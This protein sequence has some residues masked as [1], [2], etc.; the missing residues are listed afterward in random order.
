MANIWRRCGSIRQTRDRD[1]SDSQSHIPLG[2]P[3]PISSFRHD[4]SLAVRSPEMRSH[5]ITKQLS[6]PNVSDQM[7]TEIVGHVGNAMKRRYS[8]QRMEKK[9]GAMDAMCRTQID[10]CEQQAELEVLACKQQVESEV[11]TSLGLPEKP[12]LAEARAERSE[13]TSTAQ[14]QVP[15]I[16]QRLIQ[17]EM[18]RPQEATNDNA[19]RVTGP[20][21]D[22]SGP[23][24]SQVT[25]FHLST[26][27]W[28]SNSW[29]LAPDDCRVAFR[30]LE[31]P[32]RRM[33]RRQIANTTAEEQVEPSRP[34]AAPNV[35]L[36]PGPTRINAKTY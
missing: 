9:R 24:S 34:S 16:E 19:L 31:K 33:R 20:K 29:S 17:A 27:T 32:V 21:V 6:D 5:A 30:P 22:N 1:R 12:V 7:Y 8:K 10:L 2:S 3:N 4:Q 11:R 15:N 23:P 28:F 36:F 13:Q 14:G 25:G 18:D 26:N 35:V